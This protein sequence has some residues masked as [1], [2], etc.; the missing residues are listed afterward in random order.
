MVRKI[1]ARI[2]DEVLHEALEKYRWR[3]LALGAT[4]ARVITT[5]MILIDES[6]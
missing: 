2:S 3:A 4:D 1:V 5:D 6:Y